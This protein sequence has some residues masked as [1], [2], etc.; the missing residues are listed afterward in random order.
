MRITYRAVNRHMQYVIVNR[1]D[2]LNKL[3]EQLSTGKRLLRPSDDPSGVANDLQL[4]SKVK[5]LDQLKKNM[6]DG[7]GFME[8]TDTAMMSMDTLLQRLRELSVQ[9]SSDTM[10]AKERLFIATE[11]EQLARQ[12]IA[13]TNTK[14]KGDF[15]FAGTETR[16][17]P[18]PLEVSKAATPQDYANFDMAYYDA[19]TSA[20]NTPVQIR[21]AF[22]ND[23]ITNIMPGTFK[24]IVGGTQ[25]IEGTDYT[26]DYVNGTISIAPGAWANLGI[27]VSAAPNY[28]V[29]GV[30]MTF[31]YIGRGENIY[32]EPVNNDG[33][34]LR[35]IE[36]GIVTPIN[37][38][39]GELLDDPASGTNILETI[40]GL[41]ESL[42]HN[43]QPNIVNSITNIDLG[44]K[45]LLA[46][47]A[48]NGSRINRFETTM[49]R[50][51]SQSIETTRLH[52]EI[53]DAELAETATKFSVA[54]TVYNAA[55][56][57]AAKII[58]QSLVNFL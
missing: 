27:D 52:S 53:E 45:T 36:T 25:Y 26:V 21:D 28:Q 11:V 50:N 38:T 58:Q 6:D 44:F 16:I 3:Q 43:D 24:L 41:G 9:A 35:E 19:S 42:L 30:A 22:T 33:E 46:A 40:I 5:Q 18:F 10:S 47:Q 15:V 1:Y 4:R 17:M 23:P 31:E 29:G 57:S 49:E 56:Q 51:E 7:K 55:L 12:Y 14:Y 8:I 37:I 20:P 39:A 48:K 54:E 34:I 32:G 2:D 13:L